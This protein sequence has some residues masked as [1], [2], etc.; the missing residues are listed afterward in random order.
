MD[1]EKDWTNGG[2]D[3]STYT[4]DGNAHTM[5]ETII[6]LTFIFPSGSSPKKFIRLPH[7]WTEQQQCSLSLPNEWHDFKMQ[8]YTR[9][10]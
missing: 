10:V 1:I 3:V 9:K 5:K 8:V 2:L 4:Q 6:E 7:Q